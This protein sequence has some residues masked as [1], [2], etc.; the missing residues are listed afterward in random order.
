MTKLLVAVLPYSADLLASHIIIP[1]TNYF[2]KR[3]KQRHVSNHFSESLRTRPRRHESWLWWHWHTYTSQTLF[4]LAVMKT[5]RD[6]PTI[7]HRTARKMLSQPFQESSVSPKFH[8][9]N[10]SGVKTRYSPC[11]TSVSRA[12]QA[13]TLHLMVRLFLRPTSYHQALSLSYIGSSI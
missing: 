8:P 9:A 7:W 10:E 3:Y 12:T 2:R 11:F 13:R 6:R 5:T 4:K 1:H